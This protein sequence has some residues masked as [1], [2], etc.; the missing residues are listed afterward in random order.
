MKLVRLFAVALIVLPAAFAT[1]TKARAAT[2]DDCL[3]LIDTL[4]SET[5]TA[6]FFGKNAAKE[7]AG[8]VAKLDAAAAD[9]EAGKPLDAIQKLTDYQE[10]LVKIAMQGKIDPTEAEILISDAEFVIECVQLTLIPQG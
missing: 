5:Q 4:I 1:P 3:A 8:L 6:T 9:L 7:Q 2:V 10:H